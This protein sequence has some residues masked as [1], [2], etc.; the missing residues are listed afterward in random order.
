VKH[1]L[2]LI[3]IWYSRCSL[4]KWTRSKNWWFFWHIRWHYCSIWC[5]L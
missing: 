1:I 2:A 5:L 3:I 4:I